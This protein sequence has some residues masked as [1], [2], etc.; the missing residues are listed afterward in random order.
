VVPYENT[1]GR[2]LNA[3]SVCLSFGRQA[4]ENQDRLQAE[5]WWGVVPRSLRADDVLLIL[6]AI[7]RGE[8]ALVVLDNASIHTRQV[9]RDAQARLQN[10]GIH[11]YYLPPYS[12]ELNLIEPILGVGKY[13]EMPERSYLTVPSLM[14]AIDQAFVRCEQRL[15]KKT[16]H[17]L[18]LAA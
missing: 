2:R 7:P 18:R 12:P 9:V 6:E 13:T 15:P 10:K 3:F 4:S 8:R 16:Q 5:L 11:L 14:E 1:E 17:Y